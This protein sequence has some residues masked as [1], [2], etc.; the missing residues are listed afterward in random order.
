MI[1]LLKNCLIP[2]TVSF[3]MLCINSLGVN[4]EDI[5]LTQQSKNALIA[6]NGVDI[7]LLQNIN[8]DN[9]SGNNFTYSRGG[10]R[11][12]K[13]LS[14][15]KPSGDYPVGTTSYYFTDPKREEIYTEEPDDHRELMVKVWYPSK[16]VLGVK[17]APYFNQSLAVD[18][19]LGAILTNSIA[20]AP[21]ART[22]SNY[23]VLLF[24][25]GFASLPEFNTINVEELASQGYIV[26]TINHT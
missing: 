8:A 7:A 14:L 2:W 9:P 23:P 24:S 3:L 21:V 26:A 12:R 11:D 18:D 25:H 20:N 1:L 15:P 16:Q 22:Q 5:H 19:S 10:Y 4:F 6:V 13:L 17:H